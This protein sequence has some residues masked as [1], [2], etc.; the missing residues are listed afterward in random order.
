LTDFRFYVTNAIYKH[1]FSTTVDS[2]T[3]K[4]HVYHATESAELGAGF[5]G[6]RYLQTPFE[7]LGAWQKAEKETV[8]NCSRAG[9]EL[10]KDLLEKF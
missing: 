2:K 5:A 6:K 3:V 7:T 1:C 4:A 9:G 8:E 10:F